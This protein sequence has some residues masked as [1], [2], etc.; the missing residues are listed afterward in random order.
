MPCQVGLSRPYRVASPWRRVK[1][2]SVTIHRER[3]VDICAKQVCRTDNATQWY[4]HKLRFPGHDPLPVVCWQVICYQPEASLHH[5]VLT[6]NTLE[7]I[8]GVVRALCCWHHVRV[9]QHELFSD[10]IL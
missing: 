3:R 1:G 6:L 9:S 5:I 7:V 10:V 2:T 8:Y 4:V